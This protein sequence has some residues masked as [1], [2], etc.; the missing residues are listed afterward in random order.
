MTLSQC[1]QTELHELR[2]AWDDSYQISYRP[3]NAL[4]PWQ[5]E[6]PDDQKVL[7][8]SGSPAVLRDLM[9]QDHY[10]LPEQHTD[11]TLSREDQQR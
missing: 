4:E 8:K 10:R 7:M 1:S 9:I 6:R 5:A 3:D 11:A 2:L